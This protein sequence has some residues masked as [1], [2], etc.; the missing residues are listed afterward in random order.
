MARSHG[1]NGVSKFQTGDG[2]PRFAGGRFVNEYG[3]VRVSTGRTAA[4]Y[5][6]RAVI[7]QLMLEQAI[8]ARINQQNDMWGELGGEGLAVEIMDVITHPPTIPPTMHVHHIDSNRQHN[9]PCNLMLLDAALHRAITI[10]NK[11][12]RAR[13]EQA[14]VFAKLRAAGGGE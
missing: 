13:R 2:H 7:E 6:H 3:Y 9:C 12:M 11:R 4:K 10:A 1:G 5:E 8:A 14:G